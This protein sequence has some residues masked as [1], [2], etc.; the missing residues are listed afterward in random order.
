MQS[1]TFDGLTKLYDQTRTYDPACFAA[2]LDW[3]ETRFPPPEFRSVLEPGVGT[4]RIALPLVARGYHLTG[5][6]ISEE[7]LRICVAQSRHLE[8]TDDL[9][10]LRADATHLPFPSEVFDLCVAVHLFYFIAD[11]RAVVREMLRVVRTG[12][13]LVLLHT[14]FGTEVPSLNERYQQAAQELGYVFPTYGVRS[15]REVVE[16]AVSLGCFVESFEGPSWSW[17]A[18]IS[19]G[20]ALEHLRARAYS[21][22]KNVPDK[23]H[24]AVMGR[25]QGE[26]VDAL[27]AEVEVP[28]RL[29]IVIV[30]PAMEPGD[31]SN[32]HSPQ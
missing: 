18:H 10:C 16:Y 7:M 12:G 11:W 6:D 15:T 30:L 2:A 8:R 27:D 17:T 9:H 21:F 23:V 14:G 32:D 3:L 4:G 29:S 31:A 22:T 13:A 28:N 1:L 26:I 24:E 5:L 19:L 20:N 25:L